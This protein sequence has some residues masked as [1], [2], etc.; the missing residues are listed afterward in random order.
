MLRNMAVQL[1]EAAVAEREQKIR[2]GYPM[3]K[4]GTGR[5]VAN[6]VLFLASGS[7]GHITGQILGVNGGYVMTG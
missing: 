4:I 3:K 7:A 1:G 2:R 6:A 5:D